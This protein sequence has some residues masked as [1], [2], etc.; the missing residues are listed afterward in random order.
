MDDLARRLRLSKC[1]VSKILNRAFEGFSYAPAT[2][3]RVDKMARRMGYQPNIHARALRT[4]RSHLVGLALPTGSLPFFG[5]LTECLE[6]ELRVAGYQVLVAHSRNDPA[7]EREVLRSLVARS[8]DGL[9][10]MPVRTRFSARSLGL[11]PGF[12]LVLLDRPIP[13][14]R[15]PLVATDNRA[16]TRELAGRLRALGHSSV[17]AFNAPKSD[18]SMVEREEGLRDAL[19]RGLVVENMANDPAPARAAVRRLAETKAR[20]TALVALSEPL[21]LGA[22]AGLRDAG[23]GIPERISFAGFDDFPLASHWTPPVTVMRQDLPRI[24]TAATAALLS[25]LR[26]SPELPA[27]VRVPAVLEWRSSVAAA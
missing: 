13:G 4:R 7:T 10:W 2:I 20:F 18:L 25:Q 17:L 26:S 19:G 6:A 5:V 24:A 23:W 14:S 27:P 15:L 21:S 1:T 11:E 22:L 9:L 16:A 8:V 3:R 12:P